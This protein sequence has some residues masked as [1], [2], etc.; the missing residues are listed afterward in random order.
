MSVSVSLLAVENE[1]M[2]GRVFTLVR[3]DLLSS[4]S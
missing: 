1:K 3:T 2:S 4:L